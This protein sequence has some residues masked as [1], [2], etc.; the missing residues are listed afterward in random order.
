MLGLDADLG[1]ECEPVRRAFSEQELLLAARRKAERLHSD[2]N[3][4]YGSTGDYHRDL[5][6]LSDFATDLWLN[7]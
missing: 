6:L 2:P 7:G 5:G 1:H 3:S 4:P